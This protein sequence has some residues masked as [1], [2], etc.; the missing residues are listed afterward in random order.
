MIS[1]VPCNKDDQSQVFEYNGVQLFCAF[2]IFLKYT[3]EY[4]M[5]AITIKP[6]HIRKIVKIMSELICNN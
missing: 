2:S 6:I 3:K 1:I 4:V 5:G